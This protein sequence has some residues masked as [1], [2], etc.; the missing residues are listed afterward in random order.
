ME[1]ICVSKKQIFNVL[2]EK[3]KFGSEL[4][5][6]ETLNNNKPILPLPFCYN[7]HSI[8]TYI[9]TWNFKSYSISWYYTLYVSI[10]GQ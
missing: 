2:V 5:C 9:Q 4:L 6:Y 7:L 10:H 3:S 1:H 8:L